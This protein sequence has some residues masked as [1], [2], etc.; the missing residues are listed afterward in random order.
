[1][2]DITIIIP[3]F[4]EIKTIKKLLNKIINLKIKKQIIVVDDGS[5]DG[6][7]NI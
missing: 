7:F 6:T 3:V 4:N 1:M 2:K 5:S